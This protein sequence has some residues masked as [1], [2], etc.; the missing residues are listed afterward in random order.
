MH[1]YLFALVVMATGAA[2][3]ATDDFFQSVP[4]TRTGNKPTAG[5]PWTSKAWLQ[6]KTGWGYRRPA[7][8][9]SRDRADLT[10]TESE[11]YAE[12]D[13]RQANWQVRIAGSLVQDWLPDLEQGG[14]WTGYA[15]TPAQ[16]S[17]RRWRRE[18]SDSYLAW[19]TRDWW[20]KAGVQTLAWG[21]SETQKVTDV[22]ARRDQRWPGQ[23]DLEAL[24]LPVPAASF[25]WRNQLDL[26]LLPAMPGDRQPAAFDE[27]DPYIRL[28]QP[29]NG[30]VAVHVRNDDK[31][32]WAARWHTRQPGLDVQWMLADVYSFDMAP[33][34]WLWSDPQSHDSVGALQSVVFAPWRQQVAGLAVQTVR[35]NWLLKTEQAWHHNTRMATRDPLTNWRPHDQWRAMAAAA[36][37]GINNLTITGEFSWRHTRNHEPSLVDA[38]WQTGQALR[39]RYALLNERL[40]LGGLALRLMGGQGQV[41]RTSADWSLSDHWSVGLSLIAYQAT[42]DGQLLFDSRHNDTLLLT[43]R[44]NLL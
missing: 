1:K 6:Q 16:R 10:R 30:N 33:T 14:Y 32:G 20:F 17:A 38:Q 27:F 23:E 37:N 2:A 12:L 31:P 4:T 44:W 34:D 15:L 9:Y 21:E 8:P 13:W 22:L 11:L 19:K 24:R 25:T 29:E 36:F 18:I 41:W 43:L 42:S 26:I 40:E 7:A 3:S 35:G 39:I 5:T 28:R